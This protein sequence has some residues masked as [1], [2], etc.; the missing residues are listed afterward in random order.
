VPLPL[1]S[2]MLRHS[3]VGITADLYGHL[4]ADVA[5]EA[6]DAM[7]TALDVAAAERRAELAARDATTSRPQRSE[8]DQ[9]GLPR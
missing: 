8:D 2:K 6:A 3:R 4:V 7:G 9:A 5:I 1:V